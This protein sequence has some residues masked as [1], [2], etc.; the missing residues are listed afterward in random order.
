MPVRILNNIKTMARDLPCCVTANN[1][2][3]STI[4]Q[5]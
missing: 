5:V 2:N 4:V 3:A 1:S